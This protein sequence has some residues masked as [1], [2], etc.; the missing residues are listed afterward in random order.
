M[1]IKYAFTI[2]FF[3]FS[4]RAFGQ[5]EVS[6]GMGLS[7]FFDGDLR[8][9]VNELTSNSSLKS[10]NSQVE[11]FGEIDLPKQSSFEWGLEYAYSIFSFHYDFGPSLYDLILNSHKPT[12]FY[13]YV[14]RGKGYEFKFG[15]GLGVRIL[16]FK[17]KLPYIVT[18]DSHALLGWG[19]ALKTQALTALGNNLFAVIAA[20]FRWDAPGTYQKSLNQLYGGS[21]RL[22]TQINFN[23][24]SFGLLVGL[25][26]KF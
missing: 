12:L 13:Y 8:D 25:T 4:F 19:T 20:N 3:V 23:S 24:I 10:F 18:Y 17:E 26:Y 21:S 14:I 5:V 15:G 1:K 16:Q 9:Y 2:L 22:G 11:F 6:A 7:Y